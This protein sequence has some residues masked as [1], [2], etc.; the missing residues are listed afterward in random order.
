MAPLLFVQV[1]YGQAFYPA[2]IL[3]GWTWL[4]V[5]LLLIV[6]YAAVYQLKFRGPGS[7]AAGWPGL[8]ALCFLAVAA[9]HVT[10]NVLQLTPGRWVAVATGQARAAAD[11]TLLPRLLHFVLGSL[12]VGGMVL[13][14]WPG[15]H[16]DAEAG[17][18]LAR[19]GARWALLATGLQ[20]ADGFWFVFA[21]PLDIL[22]PLVTGH[23]PA[24]PLLAVAMG[25]GFLT[26]MLLAQLGDPLRQRALARGAGAAL[27]LTILAMILV[28]DTVRGLY[29]S[30]AIQPARLPV[31]AQWDLVVLFAA[32][33]VLGLLSLVWVG[34]RVRADRAAAGARAKE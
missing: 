17:A 18:R 23:W 33:L 4:A 21:L 28:R 14:L 26:L 20:M 7:P 6:G 12:A 27:F 22:K 9:I 10:A 13:A 34:R 25:L 3:L 2:T 8:I 11:T 29:L 30:P 24:T 19:L 31:A 1:L 16:G 32:V 5:P 15:R